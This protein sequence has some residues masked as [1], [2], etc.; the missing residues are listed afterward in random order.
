MGT[1]HFLNRNSILEIWLLSGLL[2][3]VY[4]SF[5]LFPNTNHH[6]AC[7]TYTYPPLFMQRI[8]VAQNS[9]CY[10]E[11]RPQVSSAH[12]VIAHKHREGQPQEPDLR[13]TCR[14]AW[15]NWQ[16][17]GPTA[18]LLFPAC[19]QAMRGLLS[20]RLPLFSGLTALRTHNSTSLC[21]T[22]SV[23]TSFAFSFEKTESEYF[24][25]IHLTKCPWCAKL[26][27]GSFLLDMPT[28]YQC[29][30]IVFLDCQL[31]HFWRF[32]SG[33]IVARKNLKT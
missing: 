22:V 18:G 17:Q 10:Q 3:Y 27:G 32:S 15:D 24:A 28:C 16:L 33:G 4:S 31:L 29:G 6:Y 11:G 21:V 2:F 26:K 25:I 30:V 20:S 12:K 7:V 9:L 13:K 5:L 19:G 1:W 23:S 14:L 8:W